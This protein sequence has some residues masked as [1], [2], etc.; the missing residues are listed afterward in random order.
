MAVGALPK[1]SPVH[2]KELAC[3]GANFSRNNPCVRRRANKDKSGIASCEST[4][5]KAPDKKG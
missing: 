2:R 1:G 4:S 3:K 5:I